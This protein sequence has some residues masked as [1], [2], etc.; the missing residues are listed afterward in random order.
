MQ[1]VE[2]VVNINAFCKYC[3]W[4][5]RYVE[6]K[7]TYIYDIIKVLLQAHIGT[8]TRDVYLYVV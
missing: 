4:S 7:S 5:H 8:K 2:H 3:F 6:I 1:S